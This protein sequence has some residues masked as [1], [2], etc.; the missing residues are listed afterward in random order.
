MKPGVSV[1]GKSFTVTVIQ[2][3]QPRY[4]KTPDP[5]FGGQGLKP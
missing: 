1:K 3:Q 4:V 5:D 2:I